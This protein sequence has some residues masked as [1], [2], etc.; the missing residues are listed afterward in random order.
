[1]KQTVRFYYRDFGHRGWC[2]QT[3]LPNGEKIDVTADSMEE[4]R[5]KLIEKVRKALTLNAD[6][7]EDVEVE[8]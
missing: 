5:A 1:M 4:G 6:K 3:K 7:V 8:F 2:V